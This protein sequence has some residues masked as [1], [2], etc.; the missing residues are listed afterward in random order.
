MWFY[1]SEQEKFN[2]FGNE[3]ALIWHETNIPY[4]VWGPES[5]RTLSLKYQPSV[6]PLTA[7]KMCFSTWTKVLIQ[8]TSPLFWMH[9]SLLPCTIFYC[10]TVLICTWL[11]MIVS[12]QAVKNNGSLYAHV[13]FARSGYSPDPNDPEYQPLTAFGRTYRKIMLSVKFLSLSMLIESVILWVHD[14]N[15]LF[16]ELSYCLVSTQI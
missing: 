13:F 12:S 4:A 8:D 6:V 15:V 14:Y 2:D 11:P 9:E 3:G 7:F 10:G 1:L 16:C 5:T